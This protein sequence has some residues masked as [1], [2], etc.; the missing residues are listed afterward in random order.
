M[1]L[2]IICGMKYNDAVTKAIHRRT[3]LKMKKLLMREMQQHGLKLLLE[4]PL[5]KKGRLKVN[6]PLIKHGV[7]R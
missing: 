4:W 2:R 7:N 3:T 6:K 1:H 5:G